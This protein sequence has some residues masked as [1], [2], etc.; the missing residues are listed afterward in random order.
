MGGVV[1]F[2]V[3]VKNEVFNKK[4]TTE[5]FKHGN[6]VFILTFERNYLTAVRRIAWRKDGI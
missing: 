6:G 5:Y 1:L 3:D 4:K 2:Y